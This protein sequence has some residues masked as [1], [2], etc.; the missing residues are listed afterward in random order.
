MDLQNMPVKTKIIISIIVVTTAFAAGRYM[1]PEKVKI[2][3]K[4]VEVNNKT[5][6]KETGVKV[7]KRKTT[8]TKTVKRPD[9]TTETTVT[10]TDG[11]SKEK[12]NKD[13]EVVTKEKETDSKKEVTS[14]SDKVTISVLGGVSLTKPGT[15]YGASISKPVLGPVAIGIWG[16]TGAESSCGASVGISF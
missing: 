11:V 7:S 6:D 15:V 13:K 4:I 10:V 5:T 3:T 12:E 9:G 1:T 2:E 16:L 8:T 14:A